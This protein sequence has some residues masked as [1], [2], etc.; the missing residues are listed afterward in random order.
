MTDS[1][2]IE[3]VFPLKQVSLD[4]MHEKEAYRGEQ[5]GNATKLTIY[6]AQHAFEAVQAPPHSPAG[7]G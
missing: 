5:M 4:S 7:S 3:T 1:R 6:A 2:L